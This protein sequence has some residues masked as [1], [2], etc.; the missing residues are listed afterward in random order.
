M[1]HSAGDVSAGS[2][3]RER[4]ERRTD[5]VSGRLVEQF[6]ATLGCI[7]P[8]PEVPQFLHWCLATP[9]TP[10][11]E[12]GTDGH[13]ERGDF[14]PEVGLPRRMWAG[15]H[16][17]F[18][19]S[20]AD[21]DIVERTSRIDDIR[22]TT[23]R[24]GRLCFVTVMHDYAVDGASRITERQDIVYRGAGETKPRAVPVEEED[25]PVAMSREI[26][27]GAALLFRYSA[28]TFNAHRIHYD[29]AYARDIEGYPAL[30]V[31]GPLIATQ[32]GAI[33]A[34]CF[35]RPLRTFEF[36][37]V[38]PVFADGV[39]RLEARHTAEGLSLRATQRGQLAMRAAAT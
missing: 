12:L 8:T 10:N 3:D 16:L 32:L 5:R 38:A 24:S 19:A 14:L 23:G 22:E 17:E 33:A 11:V 34:R 27:P 31:H 36:R 9:L 35:G 20:L 28:L 26:L 4:I 1:Q 13:P 6:R 29:L 30:V 39:Y 37:S 7:P 2:E 21:S 18:R 25:E 15:G